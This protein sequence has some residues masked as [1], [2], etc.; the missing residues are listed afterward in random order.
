[1]NAKLA[2]ALLKTRSSIIKHSPEIITGIGVAGMIGSTVMAVRATPKALDILAQ[3]E[4][5]KGDKL[6]KKECVKDAW[7]VYVPAAVLCASSAA[8]IIGAT[9]KS[10]KCNAALATAYE[11]STN[12]LREYKSKAVETFGENKVKKMEQEIAQDKVNNHPVSSSQ[13]IIATTGDTLFYD[14]LSDRYFKGDLEQ[15]RKSINELNRDLNLNM[16]VSLSEFY[17]K[18]NLKHTSLSDYIGWNELIE[19]TFTAVMSEDER[20]CISVGFLAEPKSDFKNIYKLL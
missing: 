1:M 8:C 12:T 5:E 15:I 19:P 17:D 6:T 10:A 2:S 7:K 9:A 4:Y 14:E 13:V 11:I 3:A 18:L 20:P 16:Y